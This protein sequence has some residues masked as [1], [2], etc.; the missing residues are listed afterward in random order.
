M[1][2]Q[3]LWLKF[4]SHHPE[5]RALFLSGYIEQARPVVGDGPNAPRLLAKP[6][7]AE[8]LVATVRMCLDAA[9]DADS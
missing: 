5:A 8:T 6:V 4:R 1:S 9:R 7:G 2:G 3:E